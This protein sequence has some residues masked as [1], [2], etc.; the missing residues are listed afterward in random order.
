MSLYHDHMQGNVL[1]IVSDC[2]YSGKWVKECCNYLD[3]L[4]VRPCGHSAVEKGVLIKV[5]ASCR[6]GEV[7]AAP[8]FSVSG[9]VNDK[10]KGFMAYNLGKTLRETQHSSGINFTQIQCENSIVEPC[11]LNPKLTSWN[12][13][14][15][16]SRI[17]LVRG[18]NKGKAA[19]HYVL[20]NDDDAL[21]ADFV[22]KTQ[23]ARAGTETINIEK[24][25]RVLK[26]GFGQEPPNETK[27]WLE[28][29][30]FSK[31]K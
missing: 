16:S 22:E 15:E 11:T 12:K 29:N 30:H 21:I 19:W 23:G 4:E 10:N 28:K 31:Y 3:S 9:A 26:S 17:Y 27:D 5:Y 8:C 14:M 2:S 6:S 7:A 20:L 13:K 25:G 18:N 24:Y 1:T